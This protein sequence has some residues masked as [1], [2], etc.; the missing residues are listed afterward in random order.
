ML[1]VR[2]SSTR[3]FRPDILINQP[4]YEGND[5]AFARCRTNARSSEPTSRDRHPGREY[6]VRVRRRLRRGLLAERGLTFLDSAARLRFMVARAIPTLTATG[7]RTPSPVTALLTGR[8]APL[9]VTF[10]AYPNRRP[11]TSY[12]LRWRT[13]PAMTP[14]FWQPIGN[15]ASGLVHPSPDFSVYCMNAVDVAAF[16]PLCGV[17]AEESGPNGGD[18]PISGVVQPGGYSGNTGSQGPEKFA[19]TSL[20]WFSISH[21]GPSLSSGRRRA[22]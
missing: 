8:G 18:G 10:N 22:V 3:T 7:R 6:Y 11:R 13:H 16:G 5:L 2:R 9:W 17:I 20:P 1:P 21:P 12:F 14:R 15:R 19:T 4:T